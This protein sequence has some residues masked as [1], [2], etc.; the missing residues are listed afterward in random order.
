M[1]G[2]T[3]ILWAA[4][5]FGLV[6]APAHAQ[7]DKIG[8][9]LEVAK[10]ANDAVYTEAEKQQL[11]AEV[12][13]K[14]RKKFG[15]VQDPA[16]HRYVT[17]VGSVL[18]RVSKKPD[19]TWRFI[20]L[21][22]DAVNA[23]A[24]PGGYVHIT[25]GCL[26]LIA[27]ESELAGV[28]GHE[29]THVVED[30][31]IKA[32]SKAGFVDTAASASGKGDAISSA[33][34]DQVTNIALQ[35]FGRGEELESDREGLGLAAK[36]GYQPDGLRVFLQRL[37]D[38]NKNSTEKRGLFASHPQMQERLDKLAEQEKKAGKGT[39]TLEARYKQFV[40]YKP[41]PQSQIATVAAGSSGLA[42]GS[43]G[44]TK[45][46]DDKDAKKTGDTAKKDDEPAA[47]EKP[48][49]KGFG[50]GSIASGL[51]GGE[52][53]SGQTVASGGARGLDP[54]VDAKGG[55]NPGIVSVTVTK[56]EVDA[57]RKDGKLA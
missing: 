27:N 54:E 39:V 26:A 33:L 7:F 21:D 20:V 3:R 43:S 47:E 19:Y 53:K 11:G 48:K 52:K 13:A 22:T 1:T 12:S 32:L 50:L 16:V 40:S 8:K 41:V 4:A 34:V 24:A 10:K 2:V 18:T 25:K 35:G 36:A 6:A 42:S 31:T 29:L 57:F 46:A 5:A 15:V 49:K 23:F 28:L 45:K 14:I 51:G 44:S 55:P 38:R 56:A 37:A 9:G 17:L 30:H